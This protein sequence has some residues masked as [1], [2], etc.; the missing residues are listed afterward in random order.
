MSRISILF[1]SCTYHAVP[2]AQLSVN[3]APCA[4]KMVL[5]TPRSASAVRNWTLFLH[6]I[7]I[8]A[9]V[10]LSPT[11]GSRS[12]FHSQ[13]SQV[14]ACCW[15]CSFASCRSALFFLLPGVPSLADSHEQWVLVSHP[16]LFSPYRACTVLC[17]ALAPRPRGHHSRL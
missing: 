3:P 7:H 5:L 12:S 1:E 13:S 9:R 17:E 8:I 4:S 16:W 14:L 10:C 6:L 2:F 15:L 11:V